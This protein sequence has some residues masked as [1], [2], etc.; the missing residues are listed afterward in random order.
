MPEFYAAGNISSPAPYLKKVIHQAQ[1]RGGQEYCQ[2]KPGLISGKKIRLIPKG[3]IRKLRYNPDK[4]GDYGGCYPDENS[5]QAWHHG[6][7]I[8][9][10]FGKK[11]GFRTVGRNL[12]HLFSPEL[13]FIKIVRKQRG[14][15]NCDHK[16]KSR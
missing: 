9:V 13:I 11:R 5:A 14:Q 2:G 10:Q 16:R 4:K 7:P 15:E 12:S 8:F 1:E 6:L 3:I